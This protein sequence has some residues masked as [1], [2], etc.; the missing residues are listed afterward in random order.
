[1]C[2]HFNLSSGYL[3]TLF[4]WQKIVSVTYAHSFAGG[5]VV[6]V[7]GNVVV[8]PEIISFKSEKDGFYLDQVT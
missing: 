2:S 5:L 4:F 1:M 3:K 6:T 7:D 8:V